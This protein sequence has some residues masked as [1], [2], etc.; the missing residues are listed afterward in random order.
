MGI[1][2]FAPR[3]AR[4]DREASFPFE[5]YGDL[6]A[7]GLTALCIPESDGGKGERGAPPVSGNVAGGQENVGEQQISLEGSAL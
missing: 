5:N 4:Y 6:K 1:E 2:R 7:S 3:A